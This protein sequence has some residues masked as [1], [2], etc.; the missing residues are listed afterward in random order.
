MVEQK[1]VLVVSLLLSTVVVASALGYWFGAS[2]IAPNK[3]PKTPQ[4]VRENVT[5][6]GT[7]QTPPCG[8]LRISCF[9]LEQ[10]VYA[11][12]LIKYEGKYYY[13]SKIRI[14]R[15]QTDITYT[16]WFDNSTYYC[17]SPKFENIPTCP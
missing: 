14:M 2:T 12:Q 17:I 16:Y 3:E 5:V 4:I 1:T 13:A 9:M 10:P 11:Q 8:W 7:I 15:N 6:Y